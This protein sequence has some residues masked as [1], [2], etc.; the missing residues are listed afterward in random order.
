VKIAHRAITD[1]ER[2]TY[3]TANATRSGGFRP[4][5]AGSA[6][7]AGSSAAARIRAIT[8]LAFDCLGSRHTTGGHADHLVFGVAVAK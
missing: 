2:G 4:P 8:P 7:S 5:A 1:P 6:M 3:L